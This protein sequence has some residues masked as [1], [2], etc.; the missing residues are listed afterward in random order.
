MTVSPVTNQRA[1]A[2]FLRAQMPSLQGIGGYAPRV[3]KIISPKFA[4]HT[5]TFGKQPLPM[6]APD[7]WG[8]VTTDTG[9]LVGV[10]HACAPWSQIHDVITDPAWKNWEW[11]SRYLRECWNIDEIAVHPQAR[12]Q[13]VGTQ[14]LAAAEAHAQSLG[15]RNLSAHLESPQAVA[16]FKKQGWVVLPKATPIPPQFANGL[17]THY[18]PADFHVVGHMA[19]KQLT[20]RPKGLPIPAA[21][22]P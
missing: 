10:V 2:A 12:Q 21:K 6:P 18:D 4:A 1:A 7:Y 9:Q 15:V 13:G 20:P 5:G 22:K 3:R 8:Q 11:T 14:L 19:Y 16:L 17:K